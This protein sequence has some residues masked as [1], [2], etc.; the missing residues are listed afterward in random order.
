MMFK[1]LKGK[2][3]SCSN[4]SVSAKKI[5]KPKE[6]WNTWAGGHLITDFQFC[7]GFWNLTPAKSEG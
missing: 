2:K 5:K 3:R 7:G 6:Y 4:Y 1:D